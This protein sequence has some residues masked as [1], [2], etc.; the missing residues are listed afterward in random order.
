[1]TIGRYSPSGQ[2]IASAD[3][4]GKIKIWSEHQE[5]EFAMTVKY[6]YHMLGGEIK[7]LAWDGESKR[8]VCAGDGRGQLARAF[9]FDTGSN[10]GEFAGISKR[11]NTAS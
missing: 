8:I 2:W 9:I 7:D 11:L 3:E 5:D 1:M 6:D 4:S 10:V